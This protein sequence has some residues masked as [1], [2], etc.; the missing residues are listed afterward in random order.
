MKRFNAPI[1]T[2]AILGLLVGNAKALDDNARTCG[3]CVMDRAD[4]ATGAAGGGAADPGCW[5]QPGA[6]LLFNPAFGDDIY[7]AH[8]AGCLMAGYKYMYTKLNDLR[9]GTSDVGSDEIG[10]MRNRPFDYMMIPTSMTMEMHMAMLM[11]GITDHFTIM[12]MGTYQVNEME[13]MMDMGPGHAVTTSPT[14]RTDGFGDTE[15]RGIYKVARDWTGSLGLSLP[16]GDINQSVPVMQWQFRAPYDMQLGSGTYDLK[17]A[18]TYSGL[19]ADAMWNWGAQA[20]YTWHTGDNRDD[21][22]LGDSAKFDGWL[23]RALGPASCWV[24]VAYSDTQDI[25]G[26]DPEIQKLL[27]HSDPGMPM[28]WAPIPDAD[29]ANYGG[30]R[31]D[32]AVGLSCR[33]GSGS[34]GVEGGMPFYQDLNGLQLKTDWFLTAGAEFMF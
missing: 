26:R 25:D 34:I 28:K 30:R 4:S 13:M 29:P 14:M 27:Y 6:Q 23:Q 2:L 19:S 12:A 33:I 32:G 11:Y 16:T 31:L 7:Q 3:K 22:S 5:D 9:A 20:M 18:I 15:V 1:T 17:P 21:Y 24:R 8:P 10:F